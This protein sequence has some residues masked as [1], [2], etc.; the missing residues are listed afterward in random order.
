VTTHT[1]S[2]LNHF[3][4]EI[5]TNV[6]WYRFCGSNIEKLYKRTLGLTI[7]CL[8][9]RKNYDIIHVQFSKGWGSLPAALVG[10]MVS[11]LLKKR[12]M[13]T[14]HNP[15]VTNKY[16]FNFCL[17]HADI[18]FLVSEKQRDMIKQNYNQFLPKIRTITNGFENNLFLPLNHSECRNKLNLPENK[19]IIVTIGN[20]LEVKGHIYLIEAVEMIVAK[21]QDI[22]CIIIGSGPL[23]QKLKHKIS[24]S[25]LEKNIFLVGSKSHSE[26]PIWI[27]ACDLFVLPSLSEC[28]PTVMFECLGCGKPFVGSKVGGVPEVIDSEKYGFLVESGNSHTLA[29]AIKT[30]LDKNWNEKIIL[31]H[32]SK[33]TWGEISKKI[34]E[35][36]QEKY[37][38]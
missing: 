23:E 25:N 35:A 29:E 34:E 38:S 15:K 1:Y 28:N 11:T 36:Y 10:A 32:S 6:I 26:I 2:I 31:D 8:K 9:C 21:R 7:K 12:Y 27:N 30:A 33:F 17:K 5:V 24:T 22:L 19:K 37:G 4:K 16:L 18:C 20:L 13:I 14:Y 3:S